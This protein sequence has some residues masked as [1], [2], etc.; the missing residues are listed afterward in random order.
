MTQTPPPRPPYQQQYQQP[1]QPPAYQQYPGHPGMPPKRPGGLTALAV[2]NFVFAGFGI[3][4]IP[5]AMAGLAF[6]KSQA[7]SGRLPPGF[8]M[9]PLPPDEV[10]YMQ[11]FLSFILAV[12][13]LVSGVG[14][15][16]MGKVAGYVFGNVYAL[17]NIAGD[18]TVIALNPKAL[19]G[20]LGIVGLL[21][22]A[23]YPV[24]TLILLNGP[25]RKVFSAPPVGP[26]AMGP[27]G[28]YRF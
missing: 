16:K 14:Y 2:L 15:I 9:P 25:F 27:G 20:G 6:L 17:V 12:M 3:I 13:L 22:D 1:Y 5:V 11:M 10:F 24:L 8:K 4:G 19:A 7:A 18:V 23:I 21:I 28:G 26:A